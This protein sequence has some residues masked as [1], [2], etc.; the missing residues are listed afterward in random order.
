MH[1]S[2]RKSDLASGANIGARLTWRTKDAIAPGS[3]VHGVVREVNGDGAWISLSQSLVGFVHAAHC[4]KND[5][6]SRLSRK[7]P[8]GCLR[9]GDIVRA[10]VL[11]CDFSK[12]RLELTLRDSIVS[13]GAQ[14]VKNYCS[15]GAIVVCRVPMA[16]K[17][18]KVVDPPAISVE[19]ERQSLAVV[20]LTHA[21]DSEYW[22]DATN[23]SRKAAGA[24]K[25]GS[26]AMGVV[27][28]SSIPNKVV[29]T[30][31]SAHQL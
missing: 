27:M 2:M 13:K 17:H 24:I 4:S 19:M 16:Y 25:F 12:Y 8:A 15:A 20:R 11:R 31:R 29:L 5:D 9:K 10:A 21:T 18:S 3:I 28:P 23:T 1:L 30:Y 14:G 22:R 26:Y 7:G 6:V